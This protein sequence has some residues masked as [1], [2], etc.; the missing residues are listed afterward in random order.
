MC[1]GTTGAF[2]QNKR[3]RVSLLFGKVSPLER[4]HVGLMLLLTSLEET[5]FMHALSPVDR[6]KFDSTVAWLVMGTDMAVHD[7]IMA[8]F[9]KRHYEI[10]TMSRRA[11]SF[12]AEKSGTFACTND[13]VCAR[14]CVLTYRMPSWDL[15][16]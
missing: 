14:L 13:T 2:L 7:S 16:F 3:S 4:C 6:S 9:K 15:D 12:A 11:A 1:R 10:L 5:D 8:E